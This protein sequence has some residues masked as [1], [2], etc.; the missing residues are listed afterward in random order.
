MS[1]PEEFIEEYPEVGPHIEAKVAEKGEQW[2]LD[3]YY[4][5]IY[6]AGRIFDVPEKEELPFFD[7]DEHD[8]MSKEERIEMYEAMAQ[9][10]ENLKEA[11]RVEDG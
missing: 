10:R 1:L 3:N 2:V 6:P 9:Y 7:P 4:A 8:A 5:R 11:S